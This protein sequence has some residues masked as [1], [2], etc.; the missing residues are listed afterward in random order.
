M[1][2]QKSKRFKKHKELVRVSVINARMKFIK[3]IE[4]WNK[5][6]VDAETEGDAYSKAEEMNWNEIKKLGEYQRTEKEAVDAYENAPE[7]N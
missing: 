6:M 3:K 5:K 4:Y 2:R 1:K 7:E